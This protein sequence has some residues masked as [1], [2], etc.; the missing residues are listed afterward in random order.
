MRPPYPLLLPY[1]AVLVPF[2]LV[3]S[4][5]GFYISLHRD[6]LFRMGPFA[7]IENYVRLVSD[8]RFF[9]A[10]A[11]TALYAAGSVAVIVPL[12]LVLAAAVEEGVRRFKNLFRFAWV[13]PGLTPPAIIGILFLMVFNGPHGLL[14]KVLL[15]PAGSPELDWLKDPTLIRIALVIQA[16]WRWT[17]F[18]VLFITAGLRGIP[19]VLREAAALDGASRLQYLRHVALPLLRPALRF[20]ALVLTFDAFVTFAGSYVLLGDTGGP[21]DAGLLL[22]TYTYMKAFRFGRF[23]EAAAM[24]YTMAA[25]LAALIWGYARLGARGELDRGEGP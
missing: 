18:V 4:I 24:S 5:Y 8:P 3:P 16:A 6:S 11:N 13:L 25:L 20:A 12:A 21:E 1:L 22:V 10:L 9:R 2:W 7:G 14:N 17:G 15:W 19:G 23:G